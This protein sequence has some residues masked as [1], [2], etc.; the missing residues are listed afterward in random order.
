[1][2]K[3]RPW[4]AAKPLAKDAPTR[5]RGQIRFRIVSLVLPVATLP[6]LVAQGQPLWLVGPGMAG[7]MV[8]SV[9]VIR[10]LRTKPEIFLEKDA[11]TR[12]VLDEYRA[13]MAAGT[14]SGAKY[15]PTWILTAPLVAVA[16]AIQPPVLLH[17]SWLVGVAAG[18][19]TFAGIVGYNLI[20]ARRQT[21]E[22]G[23]RMTAANVTSRRVPAVGGASWPDT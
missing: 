2:H 18:L 23:M 6:L 17:T 5:L 10:Q 11:K 4:L 14:W 8:H 22:L 9:V 19:A 15:W 7:G 1:M 21:T 13:Q 12:A 3:A 20:K 16:V